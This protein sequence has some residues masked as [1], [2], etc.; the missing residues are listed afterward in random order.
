MLFLPRL[1]TYVYK[2]KPPLCFFLVPFIC[3]EKRDDIVRSSAGGLGRGKLMEGADGGWD[4]YKQ[5]LSGVQHN[6]F[7]VQ[8]TQNES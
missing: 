3:S 1:Y 4:N 6:D 8:P 7:L 2:H 5:I